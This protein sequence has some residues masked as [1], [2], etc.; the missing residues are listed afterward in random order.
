MTP[1][2]FKQ[3]RRDLKMTQREMADHL[4]CSLGAVRH[5]EQGDRRIPGSVIK[6]IRGGK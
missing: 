1:E 4:G 3:A 6:L 2:E 5:W